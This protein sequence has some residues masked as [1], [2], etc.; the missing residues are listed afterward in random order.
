MSTYSRLYLLLALVHLATLGAAA[1]FDSLPR[2][3]VKDTVIKGPMDVGEYHT[4]S[5]KSVH[6]P[7]PSL[8]HTHGPPS[9]PPPPAPQAQPAPPPPPPPPAAVPPAPAAPPAYVYPPYPYPYPYPYP[10]HGDGHVSHDE[11]PDEH[12]YYMAHH[13]PPHDYHDSRPLHD[14]AYDE[15]YHRSHMPSY[16]DSR[17]PFDDYN[18]HM[19]PH[20]D[21]HYPSHGDDHHYYDDYHHPH[22]DGHYDENQHK[23]KDNKDKDKAS[24]A[25]ADSDTTR[26]AS[27]A[28][29]QR[30][31]HDDDTYYPQRKQQHKQSDNDQMDVVAYKAGGDRKIP[32]PGS[33]T[34]GRRFA[35]RENSPNLPAELSQLG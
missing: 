23:D 1:P 24:D 6:Y 14:F 16:H 5:D 15:D 7:K 25:T 27:L 35:T 28:L 4:Y 8:A 18:D 29:P 9:T 12:A 31:D 19:H 2:Q 33:I 34:A 21:F 22:D 3:P 13:M 32:I 20:D 10:T 30:R 11:Y 26:V 17:P